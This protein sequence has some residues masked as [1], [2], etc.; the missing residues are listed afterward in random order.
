MMGHVRVSLT[1][2][3][4][5]HAG[6]VIRRLGPVAVAAIVAVLALGS[7]GAP[8]VSAY[9]PASPSSQT[10]Q[11]SLTGT[12]VLDRENSQFP[13]EIGFG[14]LSAASAGPDDTVGGARRG[15][16]GG[17]GGGGLQPALRPGGESYDEGRRRAIL[18]DEVRTPP[19]RLTIVDTPDAVTMTTD[20]G[21]SR[22]FHPGGP[23][24]SLPLENVSVLAIA[25]READRLVVLYA[26]QSQRQLRYTFSRALGGGP[27][28]V[29][30][31]FLERGQGERIRRIYKAE[32]TAPASPG[33]GRSTGPAGSGG[34]AGP[35]G[36]PA[37]GGV[38]AAGG[39]PAA[40]SG[41]GPVAMPRNGS[42]YQGLTRLGLVIEELG[43]QAA[44]CGLRREALQAAVSKPFTDAGLTVTRDSD[45]D[46]YV[47][48]RIMTSTLASGMC[49]SRWDW[50]I[51]SMTG[52]TLSYQRSPLLLQVELARRGGMVAGAATAH[53]SELVQR[54]TEGLTTVAAAMRDA[55]R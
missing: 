15:R 3:L 39:I 38:P 53:S 34:A 8:T 25:T 26:V 20:K 23:A 29:D 31:E 24:E 45:D 4:E 7:G 48:V 22:T 36:L 37:A 35:G 16:R 42:E 1:A 43:S 2:C 10:S 11:T 46:T 50:T 52:A 55:N 49:V 30:V 12:W 18:S 44:T 5:R 19:A 32:V 41:G 47:Y 13:P 51:Y 33:S 17:G 14:A 54:L 9:Q 40:G 28:M 27:L 21:L 6:V